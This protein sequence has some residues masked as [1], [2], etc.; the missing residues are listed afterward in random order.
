MLLDQPASIMSYFQPPA[1]EFTNAY[2]VVFLTA[3]NELMTPQKCGLYCVVQNYPFANY[4]EQF[5]TCLC[6]V[7]LNKSTAAAR[8]ITTED[9]QRLVC[10]INGTQLV[11]IG[12]NTTI[13]NTSYAAN[14]YRQLKAGQEYSLGVRVW[15]W[16]RLGFIALA[17]DLG[18]DVDAIRRNQSVP[19]ANDGFGSATRT[20][21]Y[22][23]PGLFRLTVVLDDGFQEV[24]QELWVEVAPAAGKALIVAI[25]KVP[26]VKEMVR[27]Q[28]PTFDTEDE[29]SS[30]MWFFQ[31]PVSFAESTVT[32]PSRT[33]DE[34]GVYRTDV[35]VS[36]ANASQTGSIDVVVEGTVVNNWSIQ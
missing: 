31:D 14:M 19:I 29:E 21:K 5:E 17:T 8:Q 4:L 27:F 3:I 16:S 24:A 26:R 33:Y 34:P 25:P 10:C 11:G 6:G 32:K 13:V 28:V 1:S 12:I 7:Y 18:N 22:P 9:P 23:T 15:H 20:V 36:S 30:I 2:P 35:S